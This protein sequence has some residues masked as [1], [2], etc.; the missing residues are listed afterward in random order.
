MS[1]VSFFHHSPHQLPEEPE[2]HE[3]VS[4]RPAMDVT[5]TK[6]ERTRRYHITRTRDGRWHAWVWFGPTTQ[7][8]GYPRVSLVEAH[9]LCGEFR[10]EMTELERDG[11]Q[12]T[13]Q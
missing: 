10:R 7:H 6:E 4:T 1:I 8:R 13:T 11:W 2:R 9:R 12:R 5:L 3:P